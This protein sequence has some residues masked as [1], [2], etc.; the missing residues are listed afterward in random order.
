MGRILLALFTFSSLAIAQ[1]KQDGLT[2]KE[3]AD[4]KELM[5]QYFAARAWDER[6]TIAAKLQEIDHPSKG[7]IAALARHGFALARRGPLIDSKS[8]QKCT[9]P[10]FPGSYILQVPGSARARPTG[11]FISLHGGGAGV[12]DGSAIQG[13]FGMPAPGMINVFPTVTQKTDGAWNSEREEQ[14]VLAI[15]DEIKRSFLVDT[16]R[17]YLAGHSMGGFGTWSIGGRHADLFAALAPMAGGTY[18]SGVLPNLKNTPIWIFHSTDDPQVSADSDIRAAEQLAKLKAKHG[19]FDYVWKLYN[20][21]GHGIPKDGVKPI[22]D[23]MLKHA[24]DPNPKHVLWEGSRSY[25]QFFY[26]LKR[27]RPGGL[28]EAK[29][30][31][32]TIELTGSTTG[33]EILLNDKLVKLGEPVVVKVDGQERHNAKVKYSMVA[34]AESIAAKNDP[35]MVYVARI[36]P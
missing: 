21:I 13:L 36:K 12:G 16:N 25:K 24:R 6:E 8:P 27:E 18:G 22:F 19:P 14:Y 10:A 20:D 32:N 28:V 15:I 31:G 30:D 9:D 3:L 7:D 11:L 33:L 34:L 29:I 2:A 4:A 17:V 1:D 26:W 23:W 35:E 5:K